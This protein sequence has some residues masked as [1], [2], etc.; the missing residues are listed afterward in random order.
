MN[1]EAMNNEAP[2]G[3]GEESVVMVRF[4]GKGSAEF[5][6][7]WRGVSGTQLLM[8]AEYLRNGGEA[9]D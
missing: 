8:A 7:Q 9:A 6:V 4:A 5:G 2:D 3:G 1:N